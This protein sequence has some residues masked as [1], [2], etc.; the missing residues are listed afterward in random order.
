MSSTTLVPSYNRDF[1]SKAEVLDAWN[2]GLD[3]TIKDYHHPY[4]GRQINN[5]QAK[6]GERFGIRYKRLQ[7]Q[8]FII[9]GQDGF[10]VLAK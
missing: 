7:N 3:F 2:A 4:D 6:P 10:A 1:K 5:I 8:V 9:I